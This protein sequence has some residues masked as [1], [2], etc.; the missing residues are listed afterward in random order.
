MIK[1]DT[2]KLL[3]ENQDKKYREFNSKLIPSVPKEN[4]IGVRTP[5]IRQLAKEVFRSGDYEDFLNCLPHKYFEENNL[6]AFIVEQ[7][8]DFDECIKRVDEFLPY[9]DN[10]ATCDC[11]NPKAF[12]KHKD[13]L[14]EK[15][16]KWLDSEKTYTVRFGI[17]MLMSYFLDD[18]FDEKY[19]Q[20]VSRI[21]SDEYYIKMMI[22]WYFATALAKQYDNTLPYIENRFLDK[23]V[24]K[25]TIQKAVDSYR[26]TP[27]RKEHLKTLR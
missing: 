1:V 12:K 4:V 11:M 23:D 26:I 24:H 25:M 10:W 20:I 27:E 21:K 5:V 13:E 22:A 16:Y 2:K 9:V 3:F 14:L 18:D 8:K 6:H 17:K 19:L 7:I 15:I